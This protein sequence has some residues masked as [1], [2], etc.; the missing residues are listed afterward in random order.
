MTSH[1][2]LDGR[3]CGDFALKDVF[4]VT[5]TGQFSKHWNY[6]ATEAGERVSN[7]VP[8]P[9]VN[10][11]S[12]SVLARVAEPMFE[13]DDLEHYASYHS[14]PPA[15]PGPHAALTVN[16]FGRGT[17][18]YLYSSLLAK[19][20]EAQQAF[21]ESLLRRFAP[22]SIVGASNAPPCVEI[23]LL[24]A[25]REP[26]YLLCFVNFQEEAQNVP[27]HEISVSLRLPCGGRPKT[28][29]SVA[30]GRAISFERRDEHVAISVPR[31]DMM[32]M[33]ELEVEQA[34]WLRS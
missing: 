18:I 17:C 32:E 19:Q 20:Q 29:R 27:V 14:N 30:T 7:D 15:K 6:L 23:T 4:G 25:P 12:A 22:S 31:L 21:G 11:T 9:L 24:R 28:C 13:R 10:A 2:D 3:T 34:T 8:A 16:K 26:V 5:F 33:I 1:Y